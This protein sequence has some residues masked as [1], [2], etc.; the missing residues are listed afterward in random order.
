MGFGNVRSIDRWIVRGRCAM[1]DIDCGRVY[2]TF[3]R[4]VGWSVGRFQNR[5]RFIMLYFILSFEYNESSV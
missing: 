4:S 2:N 1:G 5:N 3:V